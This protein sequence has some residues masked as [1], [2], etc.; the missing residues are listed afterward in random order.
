MKI[1]TQ[2]L[3]DCPLLHTTTCNVSEQNW[4]KSVRAF[5]NQPEPEVEQF[6]QTQVQAAIEQFLE[7]GEQS[8]VDVDKEQS[9]GK[10]H[11]GYF[12]GSGWAARA[13]RFH[14]AQLKE[15]NK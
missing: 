3:A 13:L 7:Y 6:N 10:G 14:L 11:L 12:S 8:F 15:Q 5:L 9:R 1:E 4:I 2:L